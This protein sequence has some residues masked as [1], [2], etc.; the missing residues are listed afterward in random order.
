MMRENNQL[1]RE[2]LPD[3]YMKQHT[4]TPGNSSSKIVVCDTRD[5]DSK[6]GGNFHVA[7]AV[8]GEEHIF[9]FKRG[10]DK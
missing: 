10:L 2:A 5:L 8:D 9:T 4:I 7:V 1:L 6:T 3:F